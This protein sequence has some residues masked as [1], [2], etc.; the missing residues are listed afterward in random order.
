MDLS[1]IPAAAGMMLAALPP[2][3]EIRVST[4][5]VVLGLLAAW[6]RGKR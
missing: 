6:L 5:L 1:S 2:T 3:L 4:G